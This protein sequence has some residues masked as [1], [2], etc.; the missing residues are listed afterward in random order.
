MANR[1]TVRW[2]ELGASFKPS[3]TF[4]VFLPFTSCSMSALVANSHVVE[5]GK[6]PFLKLLGSDS[7]ILRSVKIGKRAVI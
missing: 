5:K 2:F 6:L 1:A 3:T 4:R 7:Y